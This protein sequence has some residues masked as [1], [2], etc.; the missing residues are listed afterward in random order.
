MS[1]AHIILFSGKIKRTS[2]TF[3]LK[4]DEL[5]YKRSWSFVNALSQEILF[6]TPFSPKL[7]TVTLK[8]SLPVNQKCNYF[9]YF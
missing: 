1:I 7:S 6:Y 5:T 9:P 8:I 3:K 2:R 4:S